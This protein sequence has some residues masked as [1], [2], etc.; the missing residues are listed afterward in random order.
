M[1][2][3]VEKC[4]AA[5]F[6]KNGPQIPMPAFGHAYRAVVDQALWAT[7]YSHKVKYL[8]YELGHAVVVALDD[9]KAE[10][11]WWR[12]VDVFEGVNVDKSGHGDL[13]AS[14]AEK[15]FDWLLAVSDGQVSPPGAPFNHLLPKWCF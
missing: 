8:G 15:I 7:L 12:G 6:V 1:S 13:P 9:P 14:Q 5:E 4:K 10:E 2:V 11:K 3:D